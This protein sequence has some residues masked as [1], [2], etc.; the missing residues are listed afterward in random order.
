MILL[1]LHKKNYKTVILKSKLQT[2]Q[3]KLFNRN[4]RKEIEIPPTKKESLF[5]VTNIGVDYFR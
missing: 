5:P 4:T 2:N 3:M 1:P